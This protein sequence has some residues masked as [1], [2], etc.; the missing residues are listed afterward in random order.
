MPPGVDARD[1]RTVRTPLCMPLAI[2]PRKKKLDQD[3]LEKWAE[4]ECCPE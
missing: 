3:K 4:K 1:R 2:G